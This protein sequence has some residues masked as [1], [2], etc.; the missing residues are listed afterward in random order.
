MNIVRELLAMGGV[1]VKEQMRALNEGVD[2][3]IGT[4]GRLDDLVSTGKIDL[5]SV[6]ML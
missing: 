3:I 6:S 1:S 4:P 2:I 5:S